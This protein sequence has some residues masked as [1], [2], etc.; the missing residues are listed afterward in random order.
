ACDESLF[1]V[2]RALRRE[3]ADVRG[4][5][6]YI[7]FGDNTLRHMAR[8]YPQSERELSR[9]PGVGAKKLEDFGAQ[10]MDAIAKFLRENPRQIYA[11][12]IEPV[13]PPLRAP[14]ANA[15]N[16]TAHMS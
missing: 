12:S 4:V 16:D 9:I 11:D 8:T 14:S 13:A 5:P 10:F 2:L 3:V 7:V 6:A 15:L 1:E